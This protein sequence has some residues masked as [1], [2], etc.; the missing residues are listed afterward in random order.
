MVLLALSHTVIVC[1]PSFFKVTP[2]VKVCAP[3]FPAVN[4]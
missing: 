4:V 2:L 1:V 3:P